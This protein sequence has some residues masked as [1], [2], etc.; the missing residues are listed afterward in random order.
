M[1]TQKRDVK[2]RQGQL[3]QPDI[4]EM[5]AIASELVNFSIQ[6][7]SHSLCKF[8]ISYKQ[9]P[10]FYFYRAAEEMGIEKKVYGNWRINRW[11]SSDPTPDI[12]NPKTTTEV[13]LKVLLRICPYP[14]T[15]T[16][17][18]AM[19]RL[20]LRVIELINRGFSHNRVAQHMRMSHNSLSEIVNNTG[21]K[22]RRPRH[23]PWRL[24][25]LLENAETEISTSPHRR[26]ESLRITIN[27]EDNV[28]LPKQQNFRFIE[29]HSPCGHCNAPWHNLKK[30]GEDA[31]GNL[32]YLC[33]LCSK[34]SRIQPKTAATSRSTAA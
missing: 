7:Y 16:Y 24:L 13:L 33:A 15:E 21:R 10:P 29:R 19:E 30:D 12:K 25:E 1:S 11:P 18:A 5:Q 26:D 6:N 2:N 17:P 34:T 22:Q 28:P 23:C 27:P 20:R 8:L 31:Y 9:L 4:F 14:E 3:Y 32:L